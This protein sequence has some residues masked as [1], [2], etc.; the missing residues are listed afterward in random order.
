MYDKL[1]DFLNE[2]L[3][4][5]KIPGADLQ[6]QEMEIPE[7][8]QIILNVLKVENP[9]DWK[10]ISLKY[11]QLLKKLHPDTQNTDRVYIIYENKQLDINGLQEMYR[12]LCDFF[13]KE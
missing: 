1:G 2:V 8:I 11:H 7:D 3:E 10:E 4:K 9:N 6:E 5:G 13:H 12:K